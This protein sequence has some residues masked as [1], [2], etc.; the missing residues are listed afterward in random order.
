MKRQHLSIK[1]TN[2][3]TL[4]LQRLSTYF[5]DGQ[6][7][8]LIQI[9]AT[10]SIQVDRNDDLVWNNFHSHLRWERDTGVVCTVTQQL[11]PHY[12][13]PN[14]YLFIRRRQAPNQTFLSTMNRFYVRLCFFFALKKHR[15]QVSKRCQIKT[16]LCDAKIDKLLKRE[17][18]IFSSHFT[19]F[20]NNTLKCNKQR[21]QNQ[22]RRQPHMQSFS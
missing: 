16:P 21:Q 2:L 8:S 22:K 13:Y 7:T 20:V 9:S 6:T 5:S 3:S 15:L 1:A 4:T 18:G 17:A 11:H 10:I 14:L 12:R 19:M